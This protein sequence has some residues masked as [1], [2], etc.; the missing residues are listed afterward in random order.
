MKYWMITCAR[1]HV[2]TGHSTE[3]KF[4][5]VAVDL[6]TACRI[7]QNMPSVKH[8]RMALYG[9]EITREE[10]MEYRQVSAYERCG[11]AQYRK[12]SKKKNRR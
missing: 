9:R 10:Y 5:I 3:I 2:G 4:A 8:T 12:T 7:A 1:G 6:L 11:Q